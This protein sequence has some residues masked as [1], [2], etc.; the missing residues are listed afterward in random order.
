MSPHP[1]PSLASQSLT[2]RVRLMLRGHQPLAT[3]SDREAIEAL[4][5]Y[6]QGVQR[7]PVRPPLNPTRAPVVEPAGARG[8]QVFDV[9]QFTG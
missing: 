8:E 1:A 5:P 3:L 7:T 6:G 9:G 2:E 4:R